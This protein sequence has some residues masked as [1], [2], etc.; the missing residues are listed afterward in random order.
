MDSCVPTHFE[1]RVCADPFVSSFD[2]LDA[3]PPR[4]VTM[5]VAPNSRELLSRRVGSSR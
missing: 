1:H 3:P 4:S 2:A 5:S